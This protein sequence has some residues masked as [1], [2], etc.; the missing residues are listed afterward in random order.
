MAA[1]I[2]IIANLQNNA[3]SPIKA[4][5]EDIEGLGTGA[6]KSAGGFSKLQAAGA[7]AT[8]VLVAGITGAAVAMG[9]FLSDSVRMAA[10]ME[11]QI[12]NIAAV[13]NTTAEAISPVKDLI[14]DLGLDPNLKVTAEEAALAIENLAKNGLTMDQVLQGA[15]YSTVLLANA[16]GADFGVAAN[17]ATDVMALFNIKAEDMKT[18]VDGITSVTVA[19]KFAINDYALALAQGGGVAAQ[20]GVSFQDFNT[21]LVATAAYF[22]SGS[23]AGTS[24]KTFIQRLVPSTKEAADMMRSLGIITDEA[25]NRFYDAEGNMQ[26]M[27]VIAGVLNE[28]ISGL[29]E[30]QKNLA[31]TTMFGSDALRF[32]GAIAGYTAEEFLALQKVMGDTD[33]LEQAQTR[34][35][36]FRG[37]WEIFLGVIDGLKLQIG[38]ALLPALKLLVEF[39]TGQL[40]VAGAAAIDIFENIIEAFSMFGEA[41]SE[42]MSPL[43]A[44]GGLVQQLGLVFGLSMD[45]ATALGDTISTVVGVVVGAVAAFAGFVGQF[46]SWK[47]VLA[48]I[49]ISIGS[50][51]IPLLA[52]LVGGFLS[53]ISPILAT[54]AIVS[55]LRNAWEANFLGIQTAVDGLVET[56]GKVIAVFAGPGGL[57]DNLSSGESVTSA[58]GQ[59]LMNLALALGLPVEAAGNLVQGFVI[60]SES[61]QSFINTLSNGGSLAD[62]FMAGLDTLKN[63]IFNWVGA[64]NWGEVGS[65]ILDQIA[66]AFSSLG[67]RA[68]E[69]AA[70]ILNW[71]TSAVNSIDWQAVGSTIVNG[72]AAAIAAVAG[73]LVVAGT[74][75]VNF[76]SG[77]FS[78]D[79][80][81]A[82][83]QGLV[84]A[85]SNAI[86]GA[87]TGISTALDGIR[88]AIFDWAGGDSWGEVGGAILDRIGE[89]FRS[90]GDR[91]AEI[92]ASIFNWI[93][94]GINSVD[95]ANVGQT[96]INALAAAVTGALG[97]LAA[98]GTAIINYFVGFFTNPDV[99]PAAQNLITALANAITGLASGIGT[100]LQSIW[101]AITTYFQNID[102]GAV[103]QAILTGISN[104]LSA[105]GIDPEAVLGPLTN[106]FSEIDRV[107]SPL[108]DRLK[109][110][111]SGLGETLAPVGEK[112]SGLGESFRGLGE[113]VQPVL[114][115]LGTLAGYVGAVFGL[116][117]GVIG[118]A[119]GVIANFL[120]NLLTGI[121]NN[122]GT[123]IGGLV[124][125][126]TGIV[127]GIANGIQFLVD[128]VRAIFQ[129]DWAAAWEA[130]K[131]YVIGLVDSIGTIL[132]GLLQIVDGILGAV[133]DAVVNTFND[134]T[135]ATLPSW[136]AFKTGVVEKLT[137][138]KDSIATAVQGWNDAI[139]GKIAE[140]S[141][142]ITSTIEGW[143]TGITT[144]LQ[145]IATSIATTV[146]G[147]KDSFTGALD[148]I[149]E[150]ISSKVEEWKQA[151]LSFGDGVKSLNVGESIKS[152]I[153]DGIANIAESIRQ[154]VAEWADSFRSFIDNVRNIN[155]GEAIV[156][157]IV[158][159]LATFMT[160]IGSTL[161]GWM[162]AFTSWV[163]GINWYDVGYTIVD[164]IIRALIEFPREVVSTLQEWGQAF[165][166]WASDTAGDL[167]DAG[168]E[169]VETVIEGLKEFPGLVADTLQEWAEAFVDW[170]SNTAGDLQDTGTE[171][172]DAIIEGLREFPGLVADTL[173]EWAQAF[174][175]WASNTATD[176]KE[177]GTEIINTIIEGLREFP[178]LVADTLSEWAQ[179][180]LDWASD[181]ASDLADTGREI[182]DAVIEGLKEF[183]GLV[184]DTLK[185][186][187]QA[188]V[189]WAS[190]TAVELQKTGTEIIN[191]I[192]TGLKEFPTLV[193]ETLK[194]WI[195][196]FAQW[197]GNSIGLLTLVGTAIVTHIITGLATFWEN[198]VNTVSTWFTNITTYIQGKIAELISL[199]ASIVQGIIS[200]IQ[201]MA[202]AVINAATGV[203]QGGID[204][205]RNA[206]GNP[207]SP[208]PALIPLGSSISE[209]LAAGIMMSS[210]L[211][212]GA[213]SDLAA[214]VDTAGVKAFSEAMQSIGEAIQSAIASFIALTGF[215]G[216]STGGALQGLA[217]IVLF[218]QEIVDA[219]VDANSHSDEVLEQ[220]GKFADTAGAILELIVDSLLP[221]RLLA[222]IDLAFLGSSA[223]L[224]GL[225][226]LRDFLYLL[227][228]AF[229]EAAAELGVMGVLVEAFAAAAE[230]VVGLVESSLKA[231]MLLSGFNFGPAVE[232]WHLADQIEIFRNILRTMVREFAEAALEFSWMG[233]AVETFTSAAES[234]IG[235][236]EDSLRAVVLLSGFNFATAVQG[237]HL[238]DQIVILRNILRT[239]V[240][241]FVEAALEFSF[242]GEAVE[243]FTSAA[244]SVVGLVEDSLR[245]IM[246]LSG[247]NFGAAVQGW[248]LADQIVIF[249]NII[250]TMVREFAEAAGEFGGMSDAVSAFAEAAEGVIGIV[251]DGL[252]AAV[253]LSQIDFGA[254]V[255]GW[256]LADQIVIFRNIIRTMVREFAEAAGEFGSMADSVQAFAEAG[257]AVV[258]LVESGLKAVEELSAVDFGALV[259]GWHLAGQIET[260]RNIIRTMM[261]EFAEAAAEFGSLSESVQAFAEAAGAVVDLIEPGIE[262]IKLLA[263]YSADTSTLAAAMQKFT[264]DIVAL[265][266]ALAS[267]F[268]QAQ[269]QIGQ[270]LTAAAEFA[271]NAGKLVDIVEPGIEALAAI[272]GYEALP[273]IR[274]A[275][276]TF[277]QQLVAVLVELAAAFAAAATSAGAVVVQAADFSESAASI[278][279]IVEPGIDALVALAT[280]APIAGIRVT[281]AA[282]GQQLVAALV[283]I[284]NA[285]SSAAASAVAA[286]G[287]A[288]T[289]SE[290]AAAIIDVIVPGIEALAALATYVPIANAQAAVS[291][292]A[293]DLVT[294]ITLLVQA[295][296]ASGI[297]AN[298][299]VVEAGEMAS[300]MSDL[301]D[302]VKPA[303]EAV[304]FL[305]GYTQVAGLRGYTQQFAADLV[306]VI[307]TLVEGLRAAGLL[308]NAAVAEAGEMAGHLQDLLKV[309]EPAIG[310]KGA[311]TLLAGYT[312]SGNL[313]AEVATFT[314]DLILVTQT[315]V[316]GL[317]QSALAAGIALQKAGEMAKNIED[318][319]KAV[320]E[321][322]DVM[323][324]LAEYQ[325]AGDLAARIQKFT[326][327]LVM[328]ATILV[329]GL[330][331]AATQLGGPAIAAAS[332]FA[333]SVTEI[334]SYMRMAV[335]EME[336]MAGSQMPPVKPVLDY[337]IKSAGEIAA[338]AQAS[339]AVG[340][341]GAYM[342]QFADAVQ[343]VV[344]EV[345]EALSHLA[346]LA[347]AN[348]PGS[349][350]GILDAM[351]NALRNAVPSFG[352]AGEALAAAVENG[353]R[354]GDYEGA[355][356]DAA[357]SFIDGIQSQEGEAV[358]AAAGIVSAML[359]AA[360]AAAR[361]FVEVGKA[362]TA[363][364]VS[365]IQST[366]NTVTAAVVKMLTDA[367]NAA[368]S[369]VNQ[370]TTL[371]QDVAKAAA[372][373]MVGMR[374]TLDSAGVQAGSALIEG[375]RRAIASGQSSVVNQIIATVRAAVAAAQN[376]LGIHSPSKVF[377]T[378]GRFLSD[379]FRLG[380]EA[381]MAPVIRAV[382]RFARNVSDTMSAGLAVSV[383]SVRLS[384]NMLA[385]P[386]SM[387]G[388]TPKYRIPQPVISPPTPP[389]ARVTPMM[390]HEETTV[391]NEFKIDLHFPGGTSA[392]PADIKRMVQEGVDEALLRSGRK[393]D[394]SRRLK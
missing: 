151:I 52:G 95:W 173:Q 261:R 112:L 245:A 188:F 232:N 25:G 244:E 92:E 308:A 174:I 335:G 197:V 342:A 297:L 233:E 208:A 230:S 358:Q 220:V 100:G 113:A 179:A 57:F 21:A 81:Q 164:F 274:T 97:L 133:W 242:M 273:G 46:V 202:Q 365:G 379:G 91:V 329:T 357:S 140:I 152:S 43:Q 325:G 161:T 59:A 252:A 2:Q 186:W 293:A 257:G 350:Q 150:A 334:A 285:L 196:A 56:V 304:V 301:V 184:A 302:V 296:Q 37:A 265:T 121:I 349:I 266:L 75:I 77:F 377:Y 372:A 356:Q 172:I 126:V 41:I 217:S 114:S 370:A 344:A 303:V 307:N 311:I 225:W 392:T 221:L 4:L 250:R 322:L 269:A 84:T 131:S 119:I 18:A 62:A 106:I 388:V 72:I 29:S 375:L 338:A 283:E 79:N 123:I 11:A 129:G 120:G 166:D 209:G 14:Q 276:T 216:A 287:Q 385:A 181:T 215:G 155:I 239:M 98:V 28:T 310:E 93:A 324:A 86:S 247:F 111:F 108:F 260:F 384:G 291:T 223:L 34:V 65:L 83:G 6:E 48:G 165:T 294:I 333:K 228:A 299:A 180:F 139:V 337:I 203:I 136:E 118:A 89:A 110:A 305:V 270:S 366:A 192:I 263:N 262:A 369:V 347:S 267:G 144:T 229:A 19:S 32:A 224:R 54:I 374:S 1:T 138:I 249:R 39:L 367:I 16:T 116:I 339:G 9:S 15:A 380:V 3:A 103:G 290:S 279:D 251:E 317:T 76:F 326:A 298:T 364:L 201:S 363:A 177:T 238:A 394:A 7:V 253:A 44:F 10:D 361:L 343:Q 210:G 99:G 383:P 390:P 5:R 348:T 237:W 332:D 80:L 190:N 94:G 182:I 222:S 143:K 38:S 306:I 319:F 8:G 82:A 204:A 235:L 315:L 159:G 176:L 199:G 170:A 60:L 148:Q 195:S 122:A 128:F 171:I 30:E 69:A 135:G 386:V 313:K 24:F 71:I 117:I 96:L 88:Q 78:N 318:L 101:T 381:G 278:L 141:T 259:Q 352:G 255:Q 327:D 31:L 149:K 154:K 323:N 169:I 226:T 282:F 146:G 320:S 115:V 157:F 55:L 286:I 167:Q 49:A 391:Y 158:N 256:H 42:G 127:D 280:Y 105:A 378:I 12:S 211:V 272:A 353:F 175:D 61:V 212:V 134:L 74:A 207:H 376:A 137:Q 23:D 70:N 185:T 288:A 321:A 246:L 63:G 178:G 187:A 36:N 362:M 142:G 51:V 73:V 147:W 371:G 162:Q 300:S 241:E 258:E 227:V 193:A 50:F 281:A 268:Q 206:L 231:I 312:S 292:F 47:D 45:Q 355:G 163:N 58:V 271:E 191:A 295:M 275:A 53:L 153:V 373:G 328:T 316:T 389:M 387:S 214:Q 124:T 85:L 341:A 130:A 213:I 35:D 20:L 156:D 289:F 354:S 277:A 145:G 331:N 125:V 90:L 64:T 102:W 27:A 13:W 183:P 132:S 393:V 340:N 200:G 254:V 104:A 22:K 314:A 66:A 240:R 168:Q 109:E 40:V 68:G 368:R 17:I 87:A 33:A 360:E 160:R 198:A 205:I 330:T 309:V 218:M 264:A 346:Q 351:A 26:S 107:F 194:T 219:F 284:A 345:M 189:D 67:D 236:V 234:I 336:T 382:D 359:N 248:H 243:A